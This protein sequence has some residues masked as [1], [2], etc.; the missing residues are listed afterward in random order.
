[1]G[2]RQHLWK[3]C[4]MDLE[5]QVLRS[6]LASRRDAI[7]TSARLVGVAALASVG[8]ASAPVDAKQK[9]KHKKKKKKHNKAV[10]PTP[11]PAP[12]PPPAPPAQIFKF[13]AEPML[14]AN[15]VP[16]PGQPGSTADPGNGQG[17]AKFTIQGNQICSVWTYATTTPAAI[18]G[19]LTEIH[20]HAGGAGVNGPVAIGFV[21]AVLGAQ[22]CTV[23]PSADCP[24]G[25]AALTN[26]K[27]SPAAFYANIHYQNFDGAARAQL[28]PDLS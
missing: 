3:V 27:N 16:P 1:M 20:I 9:H 11:T 22:V 5:P 12:P 23:C 19:P 25:E 21:P 26:I 17:T 13:E 18:L 10:T 24:G 2:D 8:L 15:Q 6:F 7:L 28:A 4:L 14:P